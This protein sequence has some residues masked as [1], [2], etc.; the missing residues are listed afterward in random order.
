M[1]VSIGATLLIYPYIEGSISIEDRINGRST[2]R[3]QMK[4]DYTRHFLRGEPVSIYTDA[5]VLL[6]AGFIDTVAESDISHNQN[7]LLSEL[8]IV[9]NTYLAEKRVVAETYENTAAGTIVSDLIT[10]YLTAE[11]ITA[12]TISAGV[13]LY[14]VVLAYPT[15]AEAIQELAEQSEYIWYITPAKV[16]HFISPTAISAPS[17][18]FATDVIQGSLRVDGSAPEYRNRQYLRARDTT[19]TQEAT[20]HGDGSQ[21]TFQVAYSIIETPTITLNG[22]AQVVERAG[23]DSITAQWF[24]DKESDTITQNEK[25]PLEDSDEDGVLD[26]WSPLIADDTLVVQYVGYYDIIVLSESTSAISSE[27]SREG[28][29]TGIVERV[30]DDQSKVTWQQ[31]YQSATRQITTFAQDAKTVQL[32]T[33]TSGFAIGQTVT[34]NLPNNGISGASFLIEVVKI[35]ERVSNIFYDLTLT[36]GPVGE[37][38]VKWFRDK[39]AA[40][41]NVSDLVSVGGDQILTRVYQF[42]ETWPTATTNPRPFEK[43]KVDT[44]ILVDTGINCCFENGKEIAWLAW[45]DS[46]SAGAGGILGHELGRKP[47]ANLT[48]TASQLHSIQVIAPAEAVGQIQEVAWYGS[49]SATNTADSGVLIERQLLSHV[50][51]SLEALQIERTDTKG[52]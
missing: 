7:V 37:D 29:G 50:K 15:A 13:T 1:R 10:N 6:F 49:A 3:V 36:S 33:R 11:G 41:R 27:L 21:R 5:S 14:Q 51:T 44:G 23:F 17:A 30:E 16:L 24:W 39:D 48:V 22:V 2:A 35:T 45:G 20:F 52:Y 25:Y 43:P 8:G 4:H 18:L 26:S 19:S 28:S 31:A 42:T 40:A 12:G 9:D 34:L 32:Q 38:W 47:V 46:I